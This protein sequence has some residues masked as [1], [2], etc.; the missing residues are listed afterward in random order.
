[1]GCV[2]QNLANVA[3]AKYYHLG[4]FS[5]NL[6]QLPSILTNIWRFEATTLIWFGM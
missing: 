6:K 3:S 1:M 2:N 5:E 4:A